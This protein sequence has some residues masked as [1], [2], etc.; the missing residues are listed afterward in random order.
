MCICICVCMCIYIYILY[1]YCVCVC[2]CV[3]VCVCVHNIYIYTHNVCV[4][5]CMFVY[6]YVYIYIH[7]GARPIEHLPAAA[8]G[9]LLLCNFNQFYKIIPEI[10]GLWMRLLGSLPDASLWLLS[11]SEA[12][13]SSL[14]RHTARSD[15]GSQ[16]LIFTT[17]IEERWHSA[18]KG[19]CDLFI[20]N[21]P[22]SSHG[23]AAD[24]LFAGVPIVTLPWESMASRVATSLSLAAG[25]GP[26]LISRNFED[27]YSVALAAV[28]GGRARLEKLRGSLSVMSSPAFDSRRWGR[29]YVQGLKM[30]WDHNLQASHRSHMV[31]TEAATQQAQYT[32]ATPHPRT[33]SGGLGTVVG[34]GVGGGAPGAGGGFSS[35]SPSRGPQIWSRGWRG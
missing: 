30:M 27:Y 4:C 31:V 15:V 25:T 10:W 8:V 5:V 6:V 2:A 9:R 7:K 13:K 18:G 28:G 12:G 29:S 14:L 34:G 35:C 3:C 20:D 16:Q 33:T 24:A 21:Y 26:A 11:W 17:F 32:P 22:Y 23:T 1:I 19:V